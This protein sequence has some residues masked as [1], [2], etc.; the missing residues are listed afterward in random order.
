MEDAYL[1]DEER[2]W[3]C[4]KHPLKNRHGVCP[5]CLRD[6]LLLLCPDCAHLRPCACLPSSS[7]S[8][9]SISSLDPPRSS[10]GAVGRIGSLIDGEPAF[11]RSRSA[12]FTFIR[13]RSEVAD[14]EVRLRVRRWAAFWPF[15]KAAIRRV[16]EVM[17]PEKFVRSSSVAV[18]SCQD[19]R[20]GQRGEGR[21]KGWNWLFPSPTKVFR[22]R[23]SA[24]VVQERSPFYRA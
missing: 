8:F 21:N 4:Q 16:D 9:S 18:T 1:F 11:R 12:A 3:K 22:H 6:R 13:P 17:A 7:S 20:G 10:F 2:L 23:K 14:E 15:S 5:N 24:K 19:F